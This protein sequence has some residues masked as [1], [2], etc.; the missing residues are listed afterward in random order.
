MKK[1]CIPLFLSAA[2][3]IGCESESGNFFKPYA[4]TDLRLP[5]VP[6][7][8]NDPYFSIWSPYD[9]LNEGTTR[10]WTDEEKPLTGLLRLETLSNDV[11]IGL[12]GITLEK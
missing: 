10:H 8:V 1:K 5:A 12:M 4:N 11:V 6:I 7:I 2:L 9:H 3:L